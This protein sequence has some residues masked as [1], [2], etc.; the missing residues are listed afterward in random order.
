MA[1]QPKGGAD[2]AVFRVE[3]MYLK[4]FSFENP[5]APEIYRNQLQPKAEVNLG[6]KNRKVGDEHWEV[7]L[8]VTA[9]LK[10]EDKVVFIVEVDHGGLFLL[11]NIPQEHLNG[12]LAV[13]CPTVLFPFTRQIICQ[14]VVDGGFVPFLLDPVNFA[15]M[16]QSAQKAKQARQGETSH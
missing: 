12:V 16:F 3:K 13:E 14:A 7:S 9:T 1:E 11:R 10:A 2:A 8:S 4:D 6:I 15:A 5:N